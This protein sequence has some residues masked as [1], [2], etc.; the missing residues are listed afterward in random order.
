MA[1]ID[2]K[3]IEKKWVERWDNAKLG[4]AIRDSKKPKFSIIFAYPGIS[5]YMHIGHMRGYSYTDMIGRYKR[6][7]GFNVMFP[8]GTHASGNQAIAFAKKIEK[9]DKAWIDYLIVNGCSKEK[10]REL[11]EPENIVEYFNENYINQWK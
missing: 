3:S 10:I 2:F 8:V 6:M 4:E 1:D 11:I 9:K 5:G 7:A